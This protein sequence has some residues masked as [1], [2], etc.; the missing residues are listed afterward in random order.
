MTRKTFTPLLLVLV[1]TLSILLC[2]QEAAHS[3][4]TVKSG[5]GSWLKGWGAL[6]VETV[7]SA[8]P[9]INF[10]APTKA[11]PATGRGE[12][13]VPSSPLNAVLPRFHPPFA[14]L[15]WG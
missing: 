14:K 10:D 13:F 11:S 5:A 1:S 9:A 2:A 7:S 15:I 6:S 3:G 8:G 12:V 4:Q